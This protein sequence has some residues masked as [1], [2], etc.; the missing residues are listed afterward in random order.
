MTSSLGPIPYPDHASR[1]FSFLAAITQGTRTNPTAVLVLPWVL[2]GNQLAMLPTN[3]SGGVHVNATILSHA[4]YLAVEGGRNA[5]SGL[6]VQGV[7]A[8]NRIQ[9]E[10][11]FFRAMTLMMPNAPSLR[12]AAQT[13]FQ[14]AVDL[15]GASSSATT[16]IRQAMQA[17]GLMN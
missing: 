10:R 3:D 9:I 7:G 4:F 1:T 2:L 16:A 17:V 14:A 12:T 13:I 11:A 6:T 5:T 15:H 8:A